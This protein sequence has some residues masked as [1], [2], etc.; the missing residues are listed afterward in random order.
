M[1]RQ[2]DSRPQTVPLE[3]HREPDRARREG[4]RDP[5]EQSLPRRS[6][7]RPVTPCLVSRRY[8]SYYHISERRGKEGRDIH[9]PRRGP[10][11]G[12]G[13]SPPGDP[14]RGAPRKEAAVDQEQPDRA[15][16][17]GEGPGEVGAGAPRQEAAADPFDGDG[18]EIDVDI[19]LDTRSLP[20]ILSMRRIF[21]QAS[22]RSA[23]PVGQSEQPA[24]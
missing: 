14:G 4:R 24:A 12:P 3:G 9:H 18:S 20:Y 15:D 7:L 13:R 21:I 16:R 5:P 8:I 1:P 19:N 11:P 17:Q 22:P 23:R 6:T 2:A 10:A